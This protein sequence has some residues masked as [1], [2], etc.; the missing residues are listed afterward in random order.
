M[1]YDNTMSIIA[2]TLECK[3]ILQ[4]LSHSSSKHRHASPQAVLCTTILCK[5]LTNPYMLSMHLT[6]SSLLHDLS[7][8][9]SCV[10]IHFTQHLLRD[11]PLNP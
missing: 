3:V 10:L 8:V 5:N 4:T 9:L 1:E 2:E 6:C 11:G 7:Q